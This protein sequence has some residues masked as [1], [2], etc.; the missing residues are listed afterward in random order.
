MKKPE[1]ELR[2]RLAFLI[3]EQRARG[4]CFGVSVEDVRQHH[5][6]RWLDFGIVVEEVD[7]RGIGGAPADIPGFGQAEVLGQA[8]PLHV[9]KF[10]VEARA[11]V[12]RAVIHDDHLESEEDLV[13]PFVRQRL[14]EDQQCA[15]VR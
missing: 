15:L 2:S 13:M 5:D 3:Y 6:A 14:S 10:A 7:V 11:A 4:G 8:D 12:G 9:G 1:F